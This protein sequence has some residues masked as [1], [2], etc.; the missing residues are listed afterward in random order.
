[1]QVT[2]ELE[3]KGLFVPVEPRA[4]NAETALLGDA[5]RSRG[6]AFVDNSWSTEGTILEVE[7]IVTNA[8]GPELAALW[9]S[10]CGPLQPLA[11][12]RW[13][14]DGA[15][16]PSRI[17]Q[18]HQPE[19]GSAFIFFTDGQVSANEVSRLAGHASQTAHLPTI[20]GIASALGDTE[21]IS[22]LNVSVLQAHYECARCA[23][24]IVM[25]LGSIRVLAAK[26][27]W[28]S[29]FGTLPDLGDN[30]R[31]DAFPD[32]SVDELHKLRTQQFAVMP[33]NSI[34][35][36]IEVQN[37]GDGETVVRESWMLLSRLLEV[38]TR[39]EVEA[40]AGMLS[41]SDME[42][43]AR[44]YNLRGQAAQ[45]RQWLTSALSHLSEVGTAQV[46]EQTEAKQ[47]EEANNDPANSDGAY[48]ET[49]TRQ[50]LLRL[51]EATTDAERAEAR[52]AL[53][54]SAQVA[55]A[56]G[57]AAADEVRGRL[58]SARAWLSGGLQ[59]LAEL[60]AAGFGA[61][62]LGRKSNRAKRANTVKVSE[63]IT[64]MEQLYGLDS[65]PAEAMAECHVMF[66]EAVPCALLLMSTP[67]SEAE[68][69]TADWAL[70]MPLAHGAETYNQLFGPDQLGIKGGTADRVEAMG[71]TPL[72]RNPIQIALP[73]VS[74]ASAANREQLYHRLCVA[75]MG[76]LQ[77]PRPAV[78]QL[79]L[80]TITYTLATQQWAAP[81][82]DIH[83]L[84][85]YFGGQILTHVHV[86]QSFREGPMVPLREALAHSI[87][88]AYFTVDYPIEGTAMAL[89]IVHEWG[90]PIGSEAL[91][92]AAED[93]GGSTDLGP[94]P[95][96]RRLLSASVSATHTGALAV[97]IARLHAYVP[98]KY[99]EQLMKSSDPRGLSARYMRT[100]YDVHEGSSSV[101]EIAGRHRVPESLAPLVFPRALQALDL[102]TAHMGLGRSSESVLIVPALALVVQGCLFRVNANHS[103]TSAVAACAKHQCL[104]AEFDHRTVGLMT[105]EQVKA[106]MRGYLDWARSPAVPLAPF[107][108][109][110]G[111]SVVF[112]THGLTQNGEVTN[113]LAG[114]FEGAG[115]DRPPTDEQ[116]E[117]IADFLKER[118]AELLDAE[119][120]YRNGMF[121]A[122]TNSQ[123]LHKRM[124]MAWARDGVHPDD[125]AYIATVIRGLVDQGTGN[126]HANHLRREIAML[127]PSLLA[128]GKAEGGEYDRVSFVE[129]LRM[130][131]GG[132]SVAEMR[133]TEPPKAVWF[134][135]DELEERLSK[136]LMTLPASPS[137]ASGAGAGAGAG[138]TVSTSPR[139]ALCR[140]WSD[141]RMGRKLTKLLRHDAANVGLTVRADGFVPVASLQARLATE[142]IDMDDSQLRRIVFTDAKE[143]YA[144][145]V[146]DAGENW[147]R[148]NQGHTM[149]CV[150]LAAVSTL[151]PPGPDTPFKRCYHGTSQAAWASIK[152]T[153]LSRMNRTAIQMAIG[154]PGD[155]S[156]KI[157]SGMRAD[158]ECVIEIDMV[159]AME[160]RIE[161]YLSENQVVVC[162]GPIP[163]KFLRLVPMG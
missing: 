63:H 133:R 3:G 74:L 99:R 43:I 103:S 153:G 116:L 17:F 54:G 91:A 96:L 51:R 121:A 14:C 95:A 31:L 161:F 127:V 70:N 18:R 154:R 81:G 30:P 11:T 56:A 100:I 13:Q 85:H 162:E 132:R 123:P 159:A 136:S 141:R 76:G 39:A 16:S 52:A 94:P 27:P 108:T 122:E 139:T 111:P 84:L 117:V 45:L 32:V 93:G 83:R 106:K 163:P 147:V 35:V 46:A 124:W 42:Q 125:P 10:E 135:D 33:S 65:L 66:D 138:A 143:R 118:R 37:E 112:F 58:R 57:A 7:R 8:L 130:E 120:R 34:L 128:V 134:E 62:V 47:E 59:V 144:L 48:G 6:R 160:E 60:E 90:V 41:T 25:G 114:R 78:W 80:A 49:R 107:A 102:F 140:R 89:M 137:S 104:A 24:L 155:P 142:G 79:A 158:C 119:Y 19:D 40:L 157:I 36:E 131:L 156:V 28:D 69:N 92:A 126:L 72:G 64:P 105:E 2:E 68:N 71:A 20:L 21:S 23:V 87:V 113:M 151:L 5:I 22:Q 146:D 98:Q 73:V 115:S 38:R 67:E 110:F 1:M 86:P 109:P 88:G 44:E 152:T 61:D 29:A 149:T 50:L 82:T 26:G 15:T 4:H 9:N 12:V 55:R 150:K 101:S 75:F 77:M 129:R 145:H 148:A 97:A 53:L